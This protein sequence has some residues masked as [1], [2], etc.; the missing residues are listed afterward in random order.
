[1]NTKEVNELA[2][3][4]LRTALLNIRVIHSCPDAVAV[5]PSVSFYA[6]GCEVAAFA[7]DGAYLIRTYITVDAWCDSWQEA[8]ELFFLASESLINAGFTRSNENDNIGINRY[9]RRDSE[10]RV[11][12]RFWIP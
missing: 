4:T 1:M 11:T 7:D 5:T 10:A 2:F 12:G 3:N 9:N 6:D 8:H